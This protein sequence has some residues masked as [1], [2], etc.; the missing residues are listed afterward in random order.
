MKDKT[1]VM[2]LLTTTFLVGCGGGAGSGAGT[3]SSE[4]S[5][6]SGSGTGTGTSESSEASGSGAGTGTSESSEGDSNVST[7]M[8][9]GQTTSGMGSSVTEG[10]ATGVQPIT[11]TAGVST[12]LPSA[13]KFN[14]EALA[15]KATTLEQLEALPEFKQLEA[16]LKP[17][18]HEINNKTLADLK[19]YQEK[20]DYIRNCSEVAKVR[21]AEKSATARVILKTAT[22]GRSLDVPTPDKNW[23][24]MSSYVEFRH[25]L[26]DKLTAQIGRLDRFNLNLRVYPNDLYVNDPKTVEDRVINDAVNDFYGTNGEPFPINEYI[27]PFDNS[28]KVTEKVIVYVNG[29]FQIDSNYPLLIKNIKDVMGGAILPSGYRYGMDQVS[30]EYMQ[31]LLKVIAY[32]GCLNKSF[33]S[34]AYSLGGSENENRLSLLRQLHFV[35]LEGVNIPITDLKDFAFTEKLIIAEMIKSGQ[36]GTLFNYLRGKKFSSY[37]NETFFP[38]AEFDALV[39]AAPVALAAGIT[40]STMGRFTRRGVTGIDATY[41]HMNGVSAGKVEMLLPISVSLKGKVDGAKSTTGTSGTVAYKMGNTVLGI[42]HAYANAGEGFEVDSRQTE[43]SIAVSQS[44]GNVFIEGQLGYIGTHEVHSA[45]MT[46]NRYQLSV[47]FDTETVSPFV[48]VAYRDFGKQS[49]AAAYVGAE[50]NIDSLKTEAYVLDM[51]LNAKAGVNSK[52]EFTAS[53]E[54]SGSLSL[55]NGISFKTDLT[56]GTTEGSTF[57]LTANLSR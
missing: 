52:T 53:L 22:E 46:G 37:G 55:N 56:L 23:S 14:S 57:G 2:L 25:K 44:I 41:L 49:D 18:W 36:F 5:E 39:A 3:G 28:V 8:P 50:L 7:E 29:R 45:D 38:E 43:T 33:G 12:K 20:L 31:K 40:P 17:S 9:G 26:S 27:Y 10:G 42:V 34:S 6:A 13:P 32:E 15:A 24:E 30:D 21:E 1:Y 47:G 51:N 16:W 35:L 48:Q 54:W 4:N 11:S 19:T